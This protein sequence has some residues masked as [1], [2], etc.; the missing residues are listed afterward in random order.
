MEKGISIILPHLFKQEND[1][2]FDLSRKILANNTVGPYEI[3][4]ISTTPR[5]DL[6]YK[7]WNLLAPLCKYELI[8]ITNSDLLL[9]FGWDKNIHEI[10]DHYD[11]ISLRVV[12]LG[13]LGSYHTMIPKDFGNMASNFREQEFQNFVDSDIAG[14]PVSEPGWVWYCPSVFKKSKFIELGG[15]D[16][17]IPFP[18]ENDIA[19]KQKAEAAG[20]RFG[21]SNHSYAYH[22]QRNRENSGQKPERS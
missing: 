17:D 10:A 16:T 12:E 19:F 7:S 2:V 13:I 8:M 6:V 3:L 20:W 15:F 4:T 14:R 5:E 9:A 18:H 21:I 22:M 11:W 1:R